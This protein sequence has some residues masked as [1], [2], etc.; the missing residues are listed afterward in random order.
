MQ[1]RMWKQMLVY[2]SQNTRTLQT[3]AVRRLQILHTASD[4][5]ETLARRKIF[6]TSQITESSRRWKGT[7]RDR[8]RRYVKTTWHDR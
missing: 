6:Q 3:Q 7:V 8:K 4:V 2:K 5:G 1:K